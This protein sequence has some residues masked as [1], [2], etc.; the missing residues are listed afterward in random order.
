MYGPLMPIGLPGWF[1][2]LP[3]TE[4]ERLRA[5]LPF[6]VDFSDVRIGQWADYTDDLNYKIVVLEGVP[7]EEADE[8]ARWLFKH[9]VRTPKW[10]E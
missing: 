3:M 4:A 1:F 9:P 2:G 6:T 8:W 7:W 10:K 5:L